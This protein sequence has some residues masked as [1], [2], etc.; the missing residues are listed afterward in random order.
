M[1]SQARTQFYKQRHQALGPELPALPAALTKLTGAAVATAAHRRSLYCR[2][3][4]PSLPCS[5]GAGQSASSS[6]QALGGQS[7]PA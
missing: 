5:L 3:R 7:S 2:G 1:G 6:A 4:H